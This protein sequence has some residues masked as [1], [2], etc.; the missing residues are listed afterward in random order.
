MILTSRLEWL[1]TSSALAPLA[2][3]LRCSCKLDT[4]HAEG[5]AAFEKRRDKVLDRQKEI[6]SHGPSIME[7]LPYYRCVH[8]RCACSQLEPAL[9]VSGCASSCAFS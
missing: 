3:N 7:E 1:C 5:P 4:P 8:T 2:H 6:K 9:Q